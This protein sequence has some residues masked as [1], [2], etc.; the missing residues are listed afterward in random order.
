MPP[1]LTAWIID[2]A[3]G[4]IPS[5]FSVLGI[6]DA[7][8]VLVFLAF[9]TV[10]IFLIESLFEWLYK[11]GFMRLAQNVQHDL[12]VHT[13]SHLQSR[14]LAF[15]EK[16]RVGNLMSILNDD[17]NQLERFLNYGFND[18]LHLSILILVAGASLIYVSVPLGIIS[19]IPIPFIILGSMYYQR[20]VSP[21]YDKVRK[22]VGEIGTRLENNLSGIGV[23]K[24]FGAEAFEVGRV[25]DVSMDYK[26]ANFGAIKL[27]A[28]Y[29]P[30]IRII[31]AFGF[32]G[33]LLIGSYWA[34]N[35]MNNFT[36]GSLAFYAMMIQR[37]LWPITNLGKIFDEY[38]RAK[39]AAKRVFDVID[40]PSKITEVPHPVQLDRPI[41]SIDLQH[42][43]FS[44]KDDVFV[45]RDV[46]IHIPGFHHIG[47]AGVTGAGKTTLIKLLLRFYDVTKGSITI[48]GIDIKDLSIKSLRDAVSLVSQDV[49]IFHGN[50]Y[51]NIAYGN[52]GREK[53]AIIKVAM[54]VELHHFIMGLPEGYNT[55]VGERGVKLSGGQRQRLSIARAMLRDAPI[56]ILDEATSSVD[57]ATERKIQSNIEKVSAKKT[58]IIIAHRLSTLRNCDMIYFFEGG[59][60]IESGNHEELLS[61]GGRYADMFHKQ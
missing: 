47:I 11:R 17:I 61:L 23:I 38:E 56:L 51:E 16:N 52:P 43:F 3:S 49:Y 1:V 35:G 2:S 32:A 21:H 53:D 42:V 31:I 9:L 20:K 28:A 37:L 36:L 18:L 5:W 19:I 22:G 58:S 45:V 33:V 40:T 25:A 13:Y 57:T 41:Q 26:L 7:W 12:R 60:V 30:L 15:F 48:N 6:K 46:S 34:L 10:L 54:E 14:E 59:Q 29:V 50:F 44:Y 24:S 39:A 8:K 27:N 55:I 4:N